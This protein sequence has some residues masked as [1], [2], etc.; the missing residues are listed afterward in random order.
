MS[1]VLA[2]VVSTTIMT[3]IVMS[4][5]I[6]STFKWFNGTLD[7]KPVASTVPAPIK[8]SV[9]DYATHYGFLCHNYELIT[10]DGF[11]I[12]IYRIRKKGLDSQ[13]KCN[14]NT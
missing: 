8:D 5:Y 13:G 12:E 1:Q 7:P 14:R 4:A 9:C 6:Q 2:T 10:H 3:G 11:I